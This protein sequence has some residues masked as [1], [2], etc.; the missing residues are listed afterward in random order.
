MS[1]N[2]SR[3]S[4]R[5]IL[6]GAAALAG[7]A[8]ASRIDA[9]I[10]AGSILPTAFGQTGPE[11]SVVLMVF[12]RGGYNALFCS[13]DSFMNRSFGV[14]GTNVMDLGNGLIVD[15]PTYGTMPLIARQHMATIGVRHGLT[16]H[17]AAR[18]T[19]VMYQNQS[20]PLL[21]ASAI[22]GTASIKAAVLG[23][24]IDGNHNA[25]NGVSMQRITDTGST[26]AALG[27]ITDPTLPDREIG[28]N[29][30]MASRSMSELGMAKNPSSLRSMDEGF[31]AAIA[32]LQE[33]VKQF[34]VAE[35]AQA[36][37]LNANTTRV[38]TFT[39]QMLAAELMVHSG[40]NFIVAQNGGWDTHGDRSGATVRTKMNNTILPGLN[41]F[42]NR[43]MN[44]PGYNVTTVIMGEFA[45]SLP[46]SDHAPTLSATVIGK[47]VK[48]GTT[49]R[50]DANVRLPTGT[51]S[52]PGLWAYLASISKVSSNPFGNNPHS[53]L[54][55]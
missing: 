41:V 12:L 4:R 14:T 25:V 15:R 31:P 13:A 26:I 40:A 52:V 1:E 35:A 28:A 48:V 27:G 51:P 46:G 22:G 49:G 17:G 45:R 3:F 32:T 23:S 18:S 42:L 44:L 5:R 20:A 37:G 7:V 54:V 10:P 6:Q 9:R 16:S 11:K 34:N 39:E 30:L 8:A 50:M 43:M 53:S 2:F 21:L 19:T 29:G 33:P 36:Y 24:M 38:S 55:L 47:N